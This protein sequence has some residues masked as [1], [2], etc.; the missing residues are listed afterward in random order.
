M[1]AAAAT[2]VTAFSSS[3]ANFNEANFCDEMGKV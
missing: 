3:K 2:A 1:K